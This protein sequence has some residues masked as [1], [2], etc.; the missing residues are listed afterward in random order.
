VQLMRKIW[1][2]LAVKEYPWPPLP[3]FEPYR[4]L[5]T[6]SGCHRA[7]EIGELQPRQPL[8][9]HSRPGRTGFAGRRPDAPWTAGNIK[10][11]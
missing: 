9:P 4:F 8:Q 2:A 11:R 5:G 3:R 1:W 10:R 6:R 7:A